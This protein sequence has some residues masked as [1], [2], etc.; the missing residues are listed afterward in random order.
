MVAHAHNSSAAFVATIPT[1]AFRLARFPGFALSGFESLVFFLGF[2]PFGIGY[3]LDRVF[4]ARDFLLDQLFNRI[5]GFCIPTRADRYGLAFTTGSTGAANA[6]NVVFGM[7]WN[8]KVEH[9]AD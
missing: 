5:Q 1:A 2:R 8:V 4:E 3:F 7:A 9:M 6:V